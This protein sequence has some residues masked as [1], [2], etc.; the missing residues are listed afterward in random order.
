MEISRTGG[1][2]T[3]KQLFAPIASSYQLWARVLSLGQ[4]PRW[5]RRMVDG[6]GLAPGSSVL[7]V[8][9]GT[10]SITRLLSE[11]G[12]RV[13]SVDISPQMLGVARRRGA[14]AALASGERLPFPD[15]TFDAVTFGYLLRYVDDVP[16]ALTELV[17]VTRPGG[18]IGMVE[19]GRPSWPWRA[20]WMLYTRT[21]L[22]AAGRLIRSGWDEVGTF[23]GPS[24]DDFADRYPPDRLAVEWCMAGM[25]DVRF[26]RPSLGGGLVMWGYRR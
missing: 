14:V 8:A 6:L 17:R 1:P 2:G 25:A 10:G 20:P 5:R 21:I 19:F 24:I 13:V 18:V 23:L 3:V 12:H 9:A 26:H 16:G 4:D 11:R 15:A 7:D 22:P